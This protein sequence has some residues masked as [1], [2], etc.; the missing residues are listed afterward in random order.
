[1][2]LHKNREAINP[3]STHSRQEKNKPSSALTPTKAATGADSIA[4]P[5]ELIRQCLKHLSLNNNLLNKRVQTK[6]K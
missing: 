3:S 2:S 4:Q 5:E 6:M 1:M